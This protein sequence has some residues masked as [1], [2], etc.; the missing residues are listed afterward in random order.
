MNTW[1]GIDGGTLYDD[2]NGGTF[3]CERCPCQ[4]CGEFDGRRIAYVNMSATGLSTGL[5]WADAFT[6]IQDA[7]D[8]YPYREIQ[9]MGHGKLNIYP[10]A[11][12]PR[13]SYVKGI[14]D[15]WVESISGPSSRNR[16]R[17]CKVENANLPIYAKLFRIYYVESCIFH[18]VPEDEP[19]PTADVAR[20]SRCFSIDNCVGYG[21][22]YGTVFHARNVSNCQVIRA[23]TGI[24]CSSIVL[25]D[26]N[27]PGDYLCLN[28]TFSGLDVGIQGISAQGA[29]FMSNCHTTETYQSGLY[30][31]DGFFLSRHSD[32]HGFH[33][34]DGCTAFNANTGGACRSGFEVINANMS[35]CTATNFQRCGFGDRGGSTFVACSAVDC[36]ISGHWSCTQGNPGYHCG[37]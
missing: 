19:Y 31:G 3:A 36:C 21:N 18:G 34:V 12:I 23:R 5:S 32:W 17:F 2:V 30:S 10:G 9:V 7:V 27:N 20:A 22:G 28:N 24:S 25:D 1:I 14:G 15:F 16:V 29:G 37:G 35:N 11:S 33:S 13:C 4:E 8:V 6:N 26:D